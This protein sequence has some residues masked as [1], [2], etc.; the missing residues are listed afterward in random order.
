MRLLRFLYSRGQRVG[1][2]PSR[3]VQYALQYVARNGDAVVRVA[4]R[5]E[6][7]RHRR[8]VVHRYGGML[9]VVLL[10]G[11]VRRTVP[12]SSRNGRGPCFTRDPKLPLVVAYNTTTSRRLGPRVAVVPRRSAGELMKHRVQAAAFQHVPQRVFR[13]K[14]VSPHVGRRQHDVDQPPAPRQTQ[15][16]PQMCACSVG[17]RPRSSV[18][19][20]RPRTCL[21]RFK[22]GDGPRHGCHGNVRRAAH[23]QLRR[24]LEHIALGQNREER[25]ILL[26]LQH[27]DQGRHAARMP[28]HRE[29]CA[30][31]RHACRRS[32]ANVAVSASFQGWSDAF[33]LIFLEHPTTYLTTPPTA[34]VCVSKYRRRNRAWASAGCALRHA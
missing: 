1:R 32:A 21:G 12:S 14:A 10:T 25:Q 18:R 27:S 33:C 5:D 3:W 9:R 15:R 4:G 31:R 34:V 30:M 8:G 29:R 7:L 16:G 26:R 2:S 20:G 6:V 24:T 22:R 28:A 23:Q 17:H 13:L 19:C 11:V